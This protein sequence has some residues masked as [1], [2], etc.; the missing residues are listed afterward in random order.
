MANCR[1]CGG[2]LGLDCFNE[3]ECIQISQNIY[4]YQ[5]EE[6]NFLREQLEVLKYQLNQNNIPFFDG[7]GVP[8]PTPLIKPIEIE[9][10]PKIC[11]LPF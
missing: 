8:Y 11:H 1:A 5:D 7:L 6:I 2:K 4:Q 3:Y 10:D 9:E